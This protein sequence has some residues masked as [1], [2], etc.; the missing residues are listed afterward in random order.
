MH[1]QE[2]LSNY[3]LSIV[4]RSLFAADSTML[5]CS[6]KRILMD[7]LENMSSAETSIV[8]PP[9]I[10]QPNK[11]VAVIDTLA[12]VQSMDKPSR[13]KTCKDMS[14]HFIAFI[15]RKHGE[16]DELHIVFDRYD[17]PNSFKSA[18]RHLRLGE[19]YP[20]A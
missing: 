11:C 13:T 5:H 20:V 4:P 8:T 19:S 14:A 15:Q 2:C 18:T 17:I 3:Q 10:L 16:Y 6:A 7:M 12:G 1:P 9:E